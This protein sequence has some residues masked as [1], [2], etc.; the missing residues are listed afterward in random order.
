[1]GDGTNNPRVFYFHSKPLRD[2][3]AFKIGASECTM[4][5][6]VEEKKGRDGSIQCQRYISFLLVA[7]LL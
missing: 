6:R 7:N 1:M 2:P 4:A 5:E 3:K